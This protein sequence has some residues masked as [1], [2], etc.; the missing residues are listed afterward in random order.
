VEVLKDYSNTFPLVKALRSDL[1]N[2]AKPDMKSQERSPGS[3]SFVRTAPRPL[4]KRL[5]PYVVQRMVAIAYG[6][7]LR[8]GP[9]Q[10]E[11]ARMLC[12]AVHRLVFAKPMRADELLLDTGAGILRWGAAQGLLPV[13]VVEQALRR[14]WGIAA[15]TP[16]PSKDALDAEFPPN[17][18][19][20]GGYSSIYLS[21]DH[22]GD[23]GDYIVGRTIGDFSRFRLDQE[24]PKE[25]EESDRVIPAQWDRF[26]ASLT[27][28]QRA[29]L[30]DQLDDPGLFLAMRD[31]DRLVEH[32]RVLTADQEELLDAALIPCKPVREDYPRDEAQRWVFYRTLALGSRLSRDKHTWNSCLMSAMPRIASGAV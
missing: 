29:K 30:G 25:P 24:L 5:A 16:P 28:E 14:P 8:S 7:L 4:R 27:D 18:P 9:D 2:H 13:D 11:A 26:L 10:A 3:K 17:P 1:A 15:P 31:I 23:F 12:E 21:T 19:G 6:A 32:D 22:Y 20:R